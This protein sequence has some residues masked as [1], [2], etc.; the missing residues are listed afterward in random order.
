MSLFNN[1]LDAFGLDLSDQTIKVAQLK[2][3]G[4]KLKL[5]GHN[6]IEIPEGIVENGEIKKGDE[7]ANIIRK[8]I[9]ESKPKPISTKF[10]IYSIPETKGF[11]RVVRLP[12]SKKEEIVK[13]IADEAEQ[14]FP[15]NLKESYLDWQ[16][17]PKNTGN[18]KI[19]VLVATAPKNLVDSYSR[20]LKK[21][22]LKPIAAEIESIAIIRS[23]IN[24]QQSSRPVLIIDLGKDRTSFII[25]KKPAVQFTASIPVC[26]NEFNKAVAKEFSVDIEE[27]E[28]IKLEFGLSQQGKSGRTYKA[29]LPVL[30]NLVKYI[31][32]LLDY[33][34]EHFS[35]E[36]HSELHS[37]QIK[38]K[39]DLK[40]S[41]KNSSPISKVIVCG[42]ESKIPGMNFYL[43][44]QI[45]KEVERGNP[46]I[47][48][49]NFDKDII[50]PIS[51]ED[52]LVF[53]TVLGLAMRG[54]GEY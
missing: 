7:L 37:D 52:S 46:W 18:D 28:R 4:G 21:A 14:S 50:P 17:L 39:H 25:F 16:I 53:V 9:S 34:K 33:Y 27:A 5:A 26:G 36:F 38:L 51:R 32:K 48:I 15:I 6:R 12:K 54:V 19:E 1:N 47:N 11:I 3:S 23:L 42:G 44:L 22:G 2:K 20:V 35:S 30:V 24:R 43:S 41:E 49:M 13:A 45:K 10:V 40:I 8:T 31:D 29:M